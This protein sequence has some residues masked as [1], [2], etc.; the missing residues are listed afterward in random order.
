MASYF[1]FEAYKL[2][3]TAKD[4][5]EETIRS[6]CSYGYVEKLLDHDKLAKVKMD[7]CANWVSENPEKESNDYPGHGAYQTIWPL[8]LYHK[9]INIL[10]IILKY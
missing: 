3:K 6:L 5:E 10:D 1:Y 9:N 7:E 4:H 8:Y 2:S